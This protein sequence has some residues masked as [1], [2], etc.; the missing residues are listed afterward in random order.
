MTRYIALG[1]LALGAIMHVPA[2]AEEEKAP[3]PLCPGKTDAHLVE[4]PTDPVSDL[5]LYLLAG[6]WTDQDGMRRSLAAWR[7]RPVL[8]AMMF[9]HCDY[10]CPRIVQNLRGIRRHLEAEDLLPPH[11]VLVSFD[12]ERDDA[13]R[14]KAYAIASG[15]DPESWTLLHGPPDAVREIAATLGVSYRQEENKSFAHSNVITLLNGAGE[16]VQQLQGL[17]QADDKIVM[18]VRALRQVP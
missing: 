3:C 8:L 7:G 14:L 16:V 15:L 9:T 12:S 1:A 18:A 13:E 4:M 11:V 5:S 17:D 10:A 2:H 6:T